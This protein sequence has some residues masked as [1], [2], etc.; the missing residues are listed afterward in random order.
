MVQTTDAMSS[1]PYVGIAADIDVVV[2]ITDHRQA[3][4]RIDR[5]HVAFLM[6]RVEI[7][8]GTRRDGKLVFVWHQECY[9]RRCVVAGRGGICLRAADGAIHAA[10]VGRWAASA[11][12]AR[13][14]VYLRVTLDA[15]V[16]MEYPGDEMADEQFR[17]AYYG[18]DR[19][20]IVER[21]EQIQA[22]GLAERGL[23]RLRA[24]ATADEQ[25][26]AC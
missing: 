16:Q 21:T 15:R 20:P 24:Q 14:M 9:D 5:V 7:P 4:C 26:L 18:T 10:S 8:A 22:H 13:T 23:C 11:P 25:T 19:K 1:S 12:S 2:V 17:Q 3:R 6:W